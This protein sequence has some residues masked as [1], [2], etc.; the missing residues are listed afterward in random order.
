MPDIS[1]FWDPA[2]GRGDWAQAGPDLSAGTDLETAV[3]ISLF[4]DRRAE[5]DEIIPDGSGDARGWWGD[6]GRARPLGSKLWLLERA[7]Q[8]EDTRHRAFDY[9][10]DALAWLIEDGVAATVDVLVQWQ[11]PGLLASQVTITEPSGRTS[12]F[13]YHWA[14]KAVS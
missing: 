7:K 8:T 11:R 3:I 9:I 4:T 2:A 6:T 13:N 5:P 10:T 1:T 14:W 12:V